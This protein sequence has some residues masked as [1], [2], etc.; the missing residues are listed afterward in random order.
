[1]NS[2]FPPEEKAENIQAPLHT[3]IVHQPNC[4]PTALPGYIT[5]LNKASSQFAFDPF[6]VAVLTCNL[7][8]AE[9]LMSMGASLSSL[10][11][12]GNT[13][14]HLAAMMGDEVLL[15]VLLQHA[16]MSDRAAIALLNHNQDLFEDFRFFS[17]PRFQTSCLFL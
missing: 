7:T 1:M 6:H 13:P 5:D 8:A 12:R 3:L 14:L 9:L 4:L 10:D 11:A 15:S 16:R 2:R 17:S